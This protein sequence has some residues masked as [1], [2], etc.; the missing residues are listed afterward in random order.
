MLGEVTDQ[1]LG[2]KQP[3]DL[4]RGPTQRPRLAAA[5]GRDC[6]PWALAAAASG[7]TDGLQRG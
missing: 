3:K 5:C 6:K 7:V 4:C 1:E 2:K